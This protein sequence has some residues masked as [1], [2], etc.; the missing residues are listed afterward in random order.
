MELKKDTAAIAAP[1]TH[2]AT[3]KGKTLY[4]LIVIDLK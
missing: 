1:E 3:N 2:S 4:E